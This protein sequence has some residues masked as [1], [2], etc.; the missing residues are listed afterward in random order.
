MECRVWSV[1]EG[2]EELLIPKID[3]F[4]KHAGRRKCVR[5]FHVV[6]VGEFYSWKGYK[7]VHNKSLYVLRGGDIVV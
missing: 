6:K 1:I 2:C 4:W 7:H 5:A 3:I